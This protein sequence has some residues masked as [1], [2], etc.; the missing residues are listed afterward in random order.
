VAI[1]LE[2][3]STQEHAF[4]AKA[5]GGAARGA[6]PRRL[7]A[8]L[9]WPREFFFERVDDDVRR[10]I[11][12]AVKLLEKRGVELRQI[13]IPH[14]AES[15][16]AGTQV[17]LAEALHYHQSSGYFP[18]R[19]ADYG[20]DVRSRLEQG[21]KVSA[22]EYLAALDARARIAAE[23]DEA[24]ASVDAIV[25]PSTPIAAPCIGESVVK[26]R[27]EEETVRSALVRVSRPANFTRHPAISVPCGFTAEGLPI[28]MQ[29]I[30][31]HWDEARLLEIAHFYEAETDWHTRRPSIAAL[32]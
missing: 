25:G 16:D 19:A 32:S 13:S 1:L 9:G 6:R 27:G 29:L 24:L 30:G 12:Q 17:A 31:R 14:I 28:G 22:V 8:S 20:N 4:R 11:E 23:F 2:A 10:A 3:I 5:A 26:I 21:G 7:R 18:A 15:A